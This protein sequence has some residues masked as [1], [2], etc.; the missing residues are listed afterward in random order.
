MIVWQRRIE[1]SLDKASGNTLTIT[2][3]RILAIEMPYTTLAI[4][5]PRRIQPINIDWCFT[6]LFISFAIKL[7]FFKSSSNFSLLEDKKAISTLE[8]NAETNS[9]S[10]TICQ[11]FI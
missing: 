3:S 2:G 1:N 4:L 7:F 9:D 5:F 11:S 8:N 10:I 6:K